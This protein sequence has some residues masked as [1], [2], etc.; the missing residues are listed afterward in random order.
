MSSKDLMKI[1][2]LISSNNVLSMAV[3]K[4]EP[5]WFIG[6]D[7]TI[8]NKIPTVYRFYSFRRIHYS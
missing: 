4:K 7:N 1:E 6:T 3:K 5:Q 2:I 8:I